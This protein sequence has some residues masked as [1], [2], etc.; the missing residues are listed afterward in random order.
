[1]ARSSLD[2]TTVLAVAEGRQALGSRDLSG[3]QPSGFS[4]LPCGDG[5]DV[6]FTPR[7]H[8]LEQ[9][10]GRWKTRQIQFGV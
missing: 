2:V 8:P 1:M 6:D 5:I 7:G 10:C 3:V 9:L 4:I